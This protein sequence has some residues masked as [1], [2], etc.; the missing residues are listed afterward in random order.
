MA[1]RSAVRVCRCLAAAAV[2]VLVAGVAACQGGDDT[3][4]ISIGSYV[5][6][7][8]IADT[9]DERRRGLM[10]REE[11]EEN[12]GMLFVFPESEPRSFWMRNTEISLSI[13]YID[14]DGTIVSI[15]DMTPYSEEPVPSRAPAK[16]ALE[17]NQSELAANGVR[18]GDTVTLPEDLT[19]E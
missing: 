17:V 7:A 19:A 10:F 8:E 13:A 15:H 6:T 11:L 2:L 3:V 18:P 9:P 14:A 4:R 1:S 16:Y 5:V 12:H